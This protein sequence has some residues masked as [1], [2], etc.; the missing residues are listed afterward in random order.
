MFKGIISIIF[1]AAAIA[2]FFVL[3]QPLYNETKN[4]NAQ[5]SSFE[6][7]LANSKQIQETRDSLLSQYNTISKENLDRLNKVLPSETESMKF[8][9]ET[10]SIVR[11]NGMLLKNIDIKEGGGGGSAENVNFGAGAEA[12]L[13]KTIPFSLKLSGSYGSFYS[14]L[15][16]MEKNLRLTDI[17]AVTFS[18]GETD[19]YEFNVEGTFYL[20]SEIQNEQL[21][22]AKEILGV[23]SLL[24]T[25]HL[26]LDFFDN[27]VFKSLYDFSVQLP[28]SEKGKNNPFA[29]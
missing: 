6:E 29:L 11:K 25:I 26:N 17:N 1:L 21:S 8:I 4:L 23:L 13:W 7:A 28:V 12:K 3:V 24:K 22:Q 14:F 10:E 5:K 15:K 9:L 19:F 27:T 2:T 20:V 16:D 18:A